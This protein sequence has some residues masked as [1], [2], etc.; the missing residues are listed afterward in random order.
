MG[1]SER[2]VLSLL[3]PPLSYPFSYQRRRRGVPRLVVL[4]PGVT[5]RRR[6]AGRS[7]QAGDGREG[8]RP[9]LEE[10]R[11]EGCEVGRADLAGQGAH[12]G[13]GC[14][15][16]RRV[17]GVRGLPRQPL[18]LGRR[19]RGGRDKGSGR[20]GGAGRGATARPSGRQIEVL[21]RPPAVLLVLA[22]LAI[23]AVRAPAGVVGS[24][25][26]SS[27]SAGPIQVQVAVV[28]PGGADVVVAEFNHCTRG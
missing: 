28:A 3:N 2:A 6:K 21:H 10:V 15:R 14:A 12:G 5:Q 1:K 25:A 24:S 26:S 23:V 9:Q 27:S 22:A 4:G 8:P 7:R 16:R 13:V 20:G 19:A 18:G 17:R 11:A